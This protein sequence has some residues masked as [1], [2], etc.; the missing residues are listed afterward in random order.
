MRTELRTVGAIQETAVGAIHDPKG[1]EL[2][3]TVFLNSQ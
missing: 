1:R 2:N 3:E